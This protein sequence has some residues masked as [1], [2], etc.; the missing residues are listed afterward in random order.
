[1][2]RWRRDDTV[3]LLREKH[4]YTEDKLMK[5]FVV[6][7][8][9]V[10]ALMMTAPASAQAQQS[11]PGGFGIGLGH[12]TGVA[13]IS[14]KVHS[15]DIAIQG[16]V[17]NWWGGWG[18]RWGD[19]YD[20]YYYRNRRGLGVSLDLLFN[21]PVIHDADV[22]QIAW[23]LGGGAAVG[24]SPHYMHMRGQ[25]VAG[26]EFIFP[27]VPLD[28]VLEWRPSVQI[29]PADFWLNFAGGGAHIRVYLD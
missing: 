19:R 5:K 16:V 26:L 8:V 9:A 3:C 4:N 13:G 23:N 10:F 7:I 25:F 15:G 2:S 11:R 18:A 24:V 21:M 28:L 29:V 22:V 27:D 14:G 20:R 17:G 1:M 12:S 6:A